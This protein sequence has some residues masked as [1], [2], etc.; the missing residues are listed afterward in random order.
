MNSNDKIYPSTNDPALIPCDSLGNPITEVQLVN[1][2][3]TFY[4]K[5]VG[6]LWG[7]TLYVKGQA[8]GNTAIWSS[9]NFAL[10][11]VPQ[12]QTAYMFDRDGDGRGDSIWVH[13]NGTLGGKN[14]L[15]S[16]KFTFGS[17]FDKAYTA[18]Y[19][20]GDSV[21]TIV[22][23]G[24]GF[25]TSIFTGGEEKVYTGQLKVWYTYKDNGKTSVFPTEGQL[26]DRIGPVIM[27]AE[28]SYMKDGN[29]QLT[30]S[31]SEALQ[32][33][34]ASS[35]MFNFHVWKNGIM[36]TDAKQA[37]D[38]ST[39]SA[40]Q[41]KLIFPKGAD[42][43][44]IPAVGDSVRFSPTSAISSALD[45]VNNKPHQDNPWVR[46]TGEQKVTI[47]SPGVVTLEPGSAVFDSAKA[48]IQSPEATVTKIIQD[49]SILTAEQAAAAYGTQG[50]FLGD[51]NMAELVENEI[52][53]I[54]RAVQSTPSYVDKDEAK[55]AEKNGTTPRSYTIEEIIAM[56]DNGDMSIKEAKKRFGIDP[57]I[58]EAYEN[59][60]LDSRNIDKFQRG[61]EA[62]IKQIVE[63][64]AENTELRYKATYYSSLGEFVNS[65]SDVITCNSDIFKENGQGTCLDNNGKL[66]LAWNMRAKNGRL[67][68]TGVYIARLE[69]RIKVGSKTV[70]NRTQDFLWGVRR[71]KVNALD[72]GL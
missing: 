43:D 62:D 48:I 32:D 16:V 33:N 58:A 12:I 70:V 39:S 25:G 45:L 22:A 53:D 55:E 30:I 14:S 44:I 51:L 50:H 47:T 65:N 71:G 69:Y 23:D 24:N 6:E 60:I 64:V 37:S 15:D 3:A 10:P 36:S 67:A 27:A 31:F 2:K 8:S 35:D 28:V 46:I 56:V 41:W 1:G 7:G 63:A 42:T 40:T 61:T 13:F 4:V 20:V 68:S 49:P 54:V 66:F 57:V 9:I 34:N 18:N 11:P 59:G 38:I 72:L 21:A 26:E 52:A 29:T 5:A 19:D 17:V